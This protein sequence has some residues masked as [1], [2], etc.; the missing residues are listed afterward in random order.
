MVSC[1]H[2]SSS[3]LGSVGDAKPQLKTGDFRYGDVLSEG[4][5][6]VLGVV[7]SNRSEFFR[8]IVRGG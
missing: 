3:S 5:T 6:G 2:F 7:V 4:G 1:N 8:G